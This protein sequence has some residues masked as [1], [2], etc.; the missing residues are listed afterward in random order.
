GLGLAR[1]PLSGSAQS[2]TSAQGWRRRHGLRA[3]SGRSV[4][5]PPLARRR[6]MRPFFFVSMVGIGAV[7]LQS[8]ACGGQGPNAVA[9]GG[10]GGSGPGGSGSGGTG[11]TSTSATGGAASVCTPALEPVAPSGTD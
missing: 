9:T 6:G 10:E 4:H 7:I 3:C 8:V 5:G 1:R 2:L 11:T